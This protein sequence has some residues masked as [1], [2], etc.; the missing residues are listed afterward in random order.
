MT[1][2]DRFGPLT[3]YYTGGKYF[4]RSIKRVAESKGYHLENY[5]LFTAIKVRDVKYSLK[6]IPCYTEHDVFRI[7]GLKYIPAE[8]R[9]F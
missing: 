3:I 1:A 6:L 4:H 5:G 9:D 2:R 8:E 7:L